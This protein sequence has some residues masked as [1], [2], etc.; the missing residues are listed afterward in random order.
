[1]DKL[2]HEFENEMRKI[3]EQA[4]ECGYRP[5]RFL[6][7]IS[8][9]GAVETAKQLLY[10]STYSEGLT[11]PWELKRLDISMEALVI[12]KPWSSLFTE[13]QL[14]VAKKRLKNL[15]FEIS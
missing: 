1:M 3:Y 15:G 10:S 5:T 9:K 6:Q 12:K 2:E 7:L 13:E 11:K 4:V 14:Q 8:E